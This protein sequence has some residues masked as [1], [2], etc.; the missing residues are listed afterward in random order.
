MSEVRLGYEN[1][2]AQLERTIQQLLTKQVGELIR[3]S[4]GEEGESGESGKVGE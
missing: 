2:I 3:V 1:K 4:K